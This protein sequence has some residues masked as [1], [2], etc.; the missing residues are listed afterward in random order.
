MENATGFFYW[1]R[2]PLFVVL[3]DFYGDRFAS[4][5][6]LGLSDYLNVDCPADIVQPFDF[7][8]YCMLPCICVFGN[9]EINHV[10]T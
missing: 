5:S 1:V 9:R 2:L 10:I 3:W 4:P 8:I 7:M 6:L